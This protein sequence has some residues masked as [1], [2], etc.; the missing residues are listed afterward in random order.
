MSRKVTL[1]TIAEEA[2]VSV[3][4][5]SRSLQQS[6]L[7]HP[8]T[9]TRIL[10]LAMQ[11]GYQGRSR[12]GVPARKD[13]YTLGILLPHHGRNI[14]TEI[15]T[16]LLQGITSEADANGIMLRIEELGQD[17]FGK[18]SD[19]KYL[20]RM[21]HNRLIDILVLQ[22]RHHPKDVECL[23]Q[24]I[25][26]VSLHWDYEDVTTDLVETS[27]NR[28]VRMLVEHLVGLGH[29]RLSW[30]REYYQATFFRDRESGFLQGCLEFNLPWDA[31]DILKE[32]DPEA[33]Q[34]QFCRSIQASMARGVTAFV[35]SSDRLAQD[36]AAHL[37]TLGAKV[38]ED[39]SIVGYDATQVRVG[40]GR[41]LT[42]FDPC[43]IESG[44]A[45]VRVALQ[46]LSQPTSAPI[47]Q[48]GRGRIKMGET[49]APPR[50]QS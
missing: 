29:Q 45:A 16:V 3:A 17:A 28:G 1:S 49:T 20:P 35:C 39:V 33:P 36:V 43:F 47:I 15:L 8:E 11:L 10:E 32:P 23:T 6:R 42:S 21:V 12:K 37:S 41:I 5:V 34:E 22:G 50:K 18:I 48:S 38:P 19:R 9:R 46:R 2:G 26:V 30:V 7:I 27:N 13:A 25:P 4:T 24:K 40:E 14:G 31:R 44:R